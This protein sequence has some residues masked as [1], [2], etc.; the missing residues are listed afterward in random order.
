MIGLECIDSFNSQSPS[1]R[2]LRPY[3]FRLPHPCRAIVPFVWDDGGSQ[4]R[5]HHL[6]IPQSCFFPIF[7]PSFF[8]PSA[9][10]L[11]HSDFPRLPSA[12]CPMPHAL[13]ALLTF[14]SSHPPNFLLSPFR[15]PTSAFSPMPH[16]P[17]A[18]RSAHLPPSSH[19]LNF[20]LS[21]LPHLPS[22]T[23]NMV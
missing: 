18:L 3:F 14:S 2:I 17:C 5:L 13:C 4:F 22:F 10:R 12:L 9:F 15:L 23:P 7:P 11:P 8:Q 20:F 21:R 19:L 16:A 6:P 1:R